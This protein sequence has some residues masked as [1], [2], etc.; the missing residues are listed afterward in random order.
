[1]A[2]SHKKV[3]I[4]PT[5]KV[6]SP[7]NFN[8]EAA[9]NTLFLSSS[10]SSFSIVRSLAGVGQGDG[11]EC[12]V[13]EQDVGDGNVLAAFD[14]EGKEVAGVA[15]CLSF[16]GPHDDLVLV[17]LVGVDDLMVVLIELKSFIGEGYLITYFLPLTM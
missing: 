1:M 10:L 11:L 9:S 6:I 15:E 5:Y 7:Y 17:A 14:R 12:L 3:E 2:Q 8:L 16:G 4:A 13:G